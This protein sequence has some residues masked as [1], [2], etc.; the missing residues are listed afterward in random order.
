M[1]KAARGLEEAPA[2]WIN[3]GAA[4]EALDGFVCDARRGQPVCRHLAR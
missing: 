3:V 4:Y 1:R 2:S